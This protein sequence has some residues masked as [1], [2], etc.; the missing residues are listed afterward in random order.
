MDVLP[1]YL[2]DLVAT[3]QPSRVYNFC[4]N[5]DKTLLQQVCTTNTFKAELMFCFSSVKLSNAL[6]IYVRDC[7][8]LTILNSKLN[9]QYFIVAYEDVP[10]L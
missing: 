9:C 7:D 10:D 1:L 4:G 5:D 3:E 6:P 2:Q 8:E